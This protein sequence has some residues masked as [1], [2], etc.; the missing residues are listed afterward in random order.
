MMGLKVRGG[1]SYVLLSISW[2]CLLVGLRGSGISS[3]ASVSVSRGY[4]GNRSER[5]G[6]SLFFV[7]VVA[8]VICMPDTA[9]KV[10]QGWSG[11]KCS[12]WA[13]RCEHG[14]ERCGHCCVA[15][16]VGG[17]VAQCALGH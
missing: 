8:G 15:G 3:S 5:W 10:M 7:G 16:L 17:Q 9:S 13:Q 14:G 6:Q 1:C 11:R 2:E 12:S 4:L